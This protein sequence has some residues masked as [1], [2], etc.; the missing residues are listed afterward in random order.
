[1]VGNGWSVRWWVQPNASGEAHASPAVSNF[2][3]NLSV[4]SKAAVLEGAAGCYMQRPLVIFG[5]ALTAGFSASARRPGVRLP[6]MRR[7][8]LSPSEKQPVT[9]G[10]GESTPPASSST[11]ATPSSVSVA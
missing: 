5:A 2:I 7:E 10:V 4:N 11:V 1:M 6:R 3:D 8:L 9:G